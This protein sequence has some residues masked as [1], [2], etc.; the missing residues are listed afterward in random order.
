MKKLLSAF[1][2][3]VPLI[4][5]SQGRGDTW[6]F[7]ESAQM[8]FSGGSFISNGSSSIYSSEESA[9]ISDQSGNLLF[10]VGSNYFHSNG[11]GPK[12]LTIWDRNNQI[13]Q[14]GDSLFGNFSV[15]NGTLILPMV[16]DSSK[17]LVFSI[18][19]GIYFQ[20]LYCSVIDMTLNSGL[21][22]VVIRDSLILSGNLSEKLSAVKHANG[23]DWWL[24]VHKIILNDSSDVFYKF[25]ID[26]SGVTYSDSQA[27]GTYYCNPTNYS[28]G[29]LG[30]MIFSNDGLKLAAVG[31]DLIDLFSFNR[32]TG[33]LSEWIPL[34]P[35]NPGIPNDFYYGVSFSPS[36]NRLF[37]S[38]LADNLGP[39][40]QYLYQFDLTSPNILASRTLIHQFYTPLLNLGQ[41]QI[42][43]NGKIY[44][45]TSYDAFPLQHDTIY[46][47]NL[48]VINDPD[49]LGLSCN[50]QPFSV[51]IGLGSSYLGLPNMPN[52][53][54]GALEIN[55]DS[56][57]NIQEASNVFQTL[58]AIPNP[59]T[60][61]FHIESKEK[62]EAVEAFNYTGES[63]LFS[64]GPLQEIDLRKAASGIYFLRVR[65]QN[66]VTTIK[67]LR[68]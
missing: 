52:Y 33:K 1:F 54:L 61:V 11:W 29:I 28:R 21:G 56:I 4:V 16:N 68:Q 3:F 46:N 27:I 55:C 44:I 39:T 41:H 62:I 51:P 47:K 48:S 60:G 15:T 35:P 30:E 50:F 40:D 64:K 63:I 34:D 57:N 43:P 23:S 22:G 53:S 2:L 49:S 25:L 14:N 12:Q 65:T 37:V 19:P 8:K 9:S 6:C 24:M 42:G 7:G 59:S 32:C 10:C 5:L 13:M 38:S 26:S 67:L 58:T 18:N 31:Y 36:G 20:G 66:G 45:A 17:Y